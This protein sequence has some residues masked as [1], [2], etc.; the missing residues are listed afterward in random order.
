MSVCR[1]KQLAKLPPD[2]CFRQPSRLYEQ[3][4]K[5]GFALTGSEARALHNAR[6]KL[7][8][9]ACQRPWSHHRIASCPGLRE[10]EGAEPSQGF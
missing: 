9:T 1:V 5:A 7:T 2:E 4:P 10:C 6:Y 3:L 8:L